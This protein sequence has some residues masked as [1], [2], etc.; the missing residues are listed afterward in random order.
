MLFVMHGMSRNAEQYLDTWTETADRKSI[1]LVAPEFDNPFFRLVTYDYQNGNLFGVSGTPNP[2][3]QWAYATIERVV[4]H[5]NV[6]NCW[7]IDAYD[8]FGHSA[9]G[10][11]VQRLVMLAPDTRLRLGVAANAGSYTFPDAEAAFPYGLGGVD[12][13]QLDMRKALGRRLVLLLGELDADARQGVLDQSLPAMR[14]GEHRLERGQNLFEAARALAAKQGLPF[15]WEIRTIPGVGHDP[16]RMAAA[17][18]DHF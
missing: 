12:P 11:F 17:A 18:A 13:A 16:S 2:P 5:L 15:A 6:V 14:Q 7:T 3:S 9:G 4:D 8:M 10:Q 1:L